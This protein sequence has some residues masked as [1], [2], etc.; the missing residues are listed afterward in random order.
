MQCK[1]T[2]VPK[3]ESVDVVAKTTEAIT[4]TIDRKLVGRAL[5]TTE[6]GFSGK[7]QVVG[8]DGTVIRT[9]QKIGEGEGEVPAV[10]L[11][12]ELVGDIKSLASYKFFKGYVGDNAEN[13]GVKDLYTDDGVQI[14]RLVGTAQRMC[15]DHPECDSQWKIVDKDGNRWFI[16][17]ITAD[18]KSNGMID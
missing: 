11:F 12:V 17:K 14:A 15:D 13:A 5:L 18:V 9:V 2:E 16:R 3:Y 7:H 10:E 6:A 8:G 4:G 1:Y